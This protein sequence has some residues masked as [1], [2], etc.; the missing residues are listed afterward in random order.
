MQQPLDQMLARRTK[1]LSIGCINIGC[2][3]PEMLISLSSML[4][5]QHVS[6]VIACITK[7]TTLC[8]NS[9]HHVHAAALGP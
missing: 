2:A 3:L 8:N 6:T 9:V 7:Y 5:I 4:Q 1:K